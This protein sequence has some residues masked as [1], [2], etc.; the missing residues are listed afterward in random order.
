MS[1]SYLE[2]MEQRMIS[3]T[4]DYMSQLTELERLEKKALCYALRLARIAVHNQHHVLDDETKRM[5]NRTLDQ[6]LG[7][8]SALE[9]ELDR[10]WLR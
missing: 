7:V 2:R 5:Q 10:E 1:K 6:S 4:S 3:A 9:K 8:L